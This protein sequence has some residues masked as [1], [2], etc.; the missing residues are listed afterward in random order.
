MAALSMREWIDRMLAALV[1]I[2]GAY[3]GSI[4]RD[5]SVQVIEVNKNLGIITE[6][7]TATLDRIGKLE[8]K[9]IDLDGRIRELEKNTLRR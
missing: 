4:L 8:A 6:R 2:V 3:A 5:L 9:D 7:T 1:V